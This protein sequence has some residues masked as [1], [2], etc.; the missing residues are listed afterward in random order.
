MA[1]LSTRGNLGQPVY[2][3]G[4]LFFVVTD[5]LMRAGRGMRASLRSPANAGTR[6]LVCLVECR[7]GVNG[8]VRVAGAMHGLICLKA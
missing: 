1:T 6:A 2:L 8:S 4:R 3:S 5:D 7:S